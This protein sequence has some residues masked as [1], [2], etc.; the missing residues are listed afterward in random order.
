MS[1]APVFVS[2]A[3]EGLVDEVALRKICQLAGTTLGDV[4][5][6]SGKQFVLSRLGGYNSS[7]RY[8]H[9]VVL[10]DLDTDFDCAPDAIR[11]WLARPADLMCLRV[12][13]REVEAWLL[14]DRDS[15]AAFLGVRP[16]LVPVTP[17]DAH[18]PKLALI[19]LARRSRS[20]AIRE[21][22][23]PEPGSGRSEGPAY[24]ARMIEFIAG[25]WR[26]AIAAA[27]SP[28][29]RRCIDAIASLAAKPYPVRGGS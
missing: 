13:V 27:H 29:L 23:V 2:A 8:R 15:T 24:A 26:P 9:W 1:A 6:R 28:S 11:S 14:A 21:D 18:D 5:G 16:Q 25:H 12:A 4:Y 17:D 10:L 3:V 22:I 7:A 19:D 20:R